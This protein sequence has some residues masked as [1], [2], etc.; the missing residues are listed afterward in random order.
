MLITEFGW[1]GECG[2]CKNTG[3]INQY[4]VIKNNTTREESKRH[5]A[6]MW[7]VFKKLDIPRYYWTL[8]GDPRHSLCG[9]TIDE[10]TGTQVSMLNG[11][12]ITDKKTGEFI[13]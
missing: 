3:C 7:E 9:D 1:P 12:R 13:F 5:Q 10:I 11:W 2:Q 8:S 4:Q 6:M